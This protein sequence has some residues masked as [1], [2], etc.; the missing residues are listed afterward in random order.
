MALAL[1]FLSTY[2]L[3]ST[4]K[5]LIQCGFPAGPYFRLY[6]YSVL[7]RS[8][9][10]FIF[11]VFFLPTESVE[12]FLPQLWHPVISCP[13]RADHAFLFSHFHLVV[14]V[15]TQMFILFSVFPSCPILA[16]IIH[17]NCYHYFCK[18][19]INIGHN[20]CPW[21]TESF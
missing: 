7:N 12:S 6:S 4:D 15:Y 9:L 18:Y 13:V 19:F 1:W 3:L 17:E 14:V 10:W 20:K 8:Q 21:F 2:L 5:K 16:Y 11:S